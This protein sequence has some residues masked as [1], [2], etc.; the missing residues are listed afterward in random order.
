MFLVCECKLG[1]GPALTAQDWQLPGLWLDQESLLA[2]VTDGQ[3]HYR[4]PPPLG[5]LAGGLRLVARQADVL[6]FNPHHEGQT[7]AAKL[8]SFFHAFQNKSVAELAQVAFES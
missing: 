6:H 2:W 3:S 4:L 1:L 8:S 5:S 7:E